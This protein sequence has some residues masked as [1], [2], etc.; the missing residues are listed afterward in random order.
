M[1]SVDNKKMYFFLVL[2]T[3]ISYCG[4]RVWMTLFNNF[5]VEEA[6]FNG[7]MIG[8]LQ[9]I[10][11][12]PGFLALLV[13]FMLPFISEHRLASLSVILL[14][15]G[16]SATGFFPSYTGLIITTLLMSFGFHYFETLNQ[17]LTLQYFSKHESPVIFGK[18]RAYAAITSIV[19]GGLIF[20]LAQWMTYLQMFL[21]FGVVV[22]IGGIYSLFIDPSDKKIPAQHHKMIVR[23]KYWLFYVLTMM[24]GAR[25]Q[26]FV[27]F[28]V[29]LLV[30]KFEFSI[31]E[32]SILFVIN[33][34]INYLISP[35]IG[36]M[37][38]TF[39]ERKVLSL[40]YAALIPIFLVY[41]FSDSKWV[42]GIMY[43]LDHIFFNFAIAVKTFF[44]KIGDPQ[45]IAPSMA[46]GFTIN[47]IAAVSFPVIG[48]LLWMIDS[49]IPFVV[50][51]TFSF[52]SLVFVQFI[53]K[54]I[55]FHHKS[56]ETV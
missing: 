14:G 13:V 9:S 19:M 44:H 39:G 23:K 51:A 5:A 4:L 42:V 10:R 24:A 21:L 11:E 18:L 8:S 31:T 33:N 49:S 2:L 50:G 43:I 36:R 35:S 27:A 25:R 32:I 45:D 22:I 3:V 38:R 28:S 56:E 15:I 37:I 40:E 52:I 46:V 6:N 48:G 26:I 47:H 34:L 16:I 29:F 30:K 41:A 7:A 54:E 12:I 55:R 20:V 17:S 1:T 53:D